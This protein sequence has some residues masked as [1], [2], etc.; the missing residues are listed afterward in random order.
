MKAKTFLLILFLN[1]LLVSCAGPGSRDPV[2][3][4]LVA[5]NDFHGYLQPSPFSYTD[6]G[7]P[8]AVITVQAG[9]VATLGGLLNKLRQDDPQL[10]FVG[11][12]D[13][14]GASPPISAMWADEPSLEAM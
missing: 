14:I 5:L 13:L 2:E 11:V 4:N 7:N 3:I 1:A 10:L 12:G 6:P 8:D 9:G